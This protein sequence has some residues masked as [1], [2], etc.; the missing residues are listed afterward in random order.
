MSSV[1]NRVGT[2]RRAGVGESEEE[3]RTKL[4]PTKRYC[5]RAPSRGCC[6]TAVVYNRSACAQ[7]SEGGRG[8]EPNARMLQHWGRTRRRATRSL[9]ELA[10]TGCT[11]SAVVSVVVEERRENERRSRRERTKKDEV[12]KERAPNSRIAALLPLWELRATRRAGRG[13][14]SSET[15][16]DRVPEEVERGK[17]ATP[18]F[19]PFALLAISSCSTRRE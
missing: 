14:D 10:E 18:A 12:E 2:V 19:S 17:S 7:E 11:S 15:G 4:P 16:S 5:P 8:D 13:R 9:R 3:R 1:S 6:R